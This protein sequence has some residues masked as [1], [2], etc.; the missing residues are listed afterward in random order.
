MT[1]KLALF[2]AE[3][4]RLEAIAY[5][6][7]GTQT[8]AKDI[9]QETYIKWQASQDVEN[10]PAWLTTVCSRLALN[11][12]TSAR[13]QR[14]EY[15]G[16]WLPEPLAGATEK[17]A[18]HQVELD[19]TISMAMLVAME[20]LSPLERAVFLL[21]DIFEYRF[22]EIAEIVGKRADACRQAA[23]RARKRLKASKPRFKVDEEIHTRLLQ[24]FMY[25][26]KNGD[27]DQFKALLA[28]DAVLI[29][30]GGGKASAALKPLHGPEVIAHFLARVWQNMIRKNVASEWRF[31]PINGSP[32]LM[33]YQ[34]GKL[35]TAISLDVHDDRIQ[36]LYAIRNP[37]KLRNLPPAPEA[38]SE[39]GSESLS[40]TFR[41]R[42]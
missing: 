10:P 20:M 21:H 8:D 33:I 5:R 37:E 26:A 23:S 1:D 25:A 38:A 4:N 7:L 22:D 31:H 41:D 36:T 3:R 27:L 17:T 34:E 18:S 19:E 39:T 15:V 42:H 2:E 14:E 28:E 29:A 40:K 24:G 16:V 35:V 32:G 9:V 11:Q 6:M 13:A 12:L 30:D